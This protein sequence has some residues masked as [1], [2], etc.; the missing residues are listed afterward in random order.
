MKWSVD[1]C[2]PTARLTSVLCYS[3]CST[4]LGLPLFLTSAE[5]V[6]R[7]YCKNAALNLFRCVW[8]GANDGSSVSPSSRNSPTFHLIKMKYFIELLIIASRKSEQ[9]TFIDDIYN[10][11]KLKH[12]QCKYHKI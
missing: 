3:L 7:N 10:P 5:N 11:T 6:L 12:A 1:A 2:M 4:K 9:K 8:V